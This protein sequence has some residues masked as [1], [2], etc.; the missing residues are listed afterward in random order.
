LLFLLI[1]SHFAIKLDT[2]LEFYRYFSSQYYLGYILLFSVEHLL[3]INSNIHLV[4]WKEEFILTPIANKYLNV[5]VVVEPV[6]FVEIVI[7]NNQSN[8]IILPRAMWQV[9]IERRADIERTINF[10]FI[11][12]GPR[13][14]DRSHVKIRDVNVIKLILHDT[15][16]YMKLLTV[17]FMF[18]LEYCVDNVWAVSVYA[19]QWKI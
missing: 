2:I 13:S 1:C 17:L 14:C 19:Y 5:G 6:S 12:I 8:N 11:I 10:T 7:G 3:V 18:K 4:Y 15:C 9:I 16:L